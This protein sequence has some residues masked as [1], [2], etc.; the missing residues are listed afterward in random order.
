MCQIHQTGKYSCNKLTYAPPSPI[1][2]TPPPTP[3][4]YSYKSIGSAGNP[5]A[6]AEAR[7]VMGLS[8]SSSSMGSGVNSTSTNNNNNTSNC[9]F[10]GLVH[11][12]VVGG[13][14]IF[15]LMCSSYGSKAESSSRC[16]RRIKLIYDTNTNVSSSSSSSEL[17]DSDKEKEKGKNESI[18]IAR[19]E[20]TALL[21]DV[22]CVGRGKNVLGGVNTSANP[23]PL[24]VCR[25]RADIGIVGQNHC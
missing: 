14:A 22:S 7:E 9:D 4:R 17:E 19:V 20:M 8:S 6:H 15:D 23:A 12:K 1:F 11:R 16:F 13:L 24:Q 25:R 5:F 10:N 21:F 18:R 3:P 2:H